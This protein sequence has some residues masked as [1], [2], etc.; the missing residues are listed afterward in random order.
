MGLVHCRWCGIH[1]GGRGLDVTSDPP[2]AAQHAAA[3][4]ADA[5]SALDWEG[6][7][8]DTR[9]LTHDIHRYSSKYIPQIARQAIN[10]ISDPGDL[11]LDPMVGSGTTLVEAWIGGRRALGIDLNPLAVLIARV[12]TRRIS[13][14]VLRNTVAELTLLMAALA[15]RHAG[16]LQLQATPLLDPT[17]VASENDPR[18]RD[19]WFTK[20]FQPRVLADLLFIDHAIR[21]VNDDR[22]RDLA[23]VALSDILRR[24]S[25]AHSGYPNVMFDRKAPPKPQPG[26]LFSA[27][28]KKYA[29]LVSTLERVPGPEPVV[30]LGDAR[31]SAIADNSIDAVVSH[32]PYIGSVPYAEYGLISLKW[33]GNDNRALDDQLLGG[34]RQSRDVVERFRAAY[35]D[36]L[37]DAYRVLRPGRRMFLMVGD[38]VVRGALVDLVEMT[39]EL[40]TSIGFAFVASTIRQGVNRRANKMAHE[41]L[42]FFEKPC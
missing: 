40:A 34:R 8:A 24:S 14:L 22:A 30:E 35:E 32:P 39:H 5:V 29:G 9:L 12:K 20:W 36:V 19:A 41:T 6:A 18:N 23:R 15:A 38:P 25:N 4:F 3:S 26:P 17:I 7:T 16:E 27:A 37:R 10:L 13:S 33:F 31:H 1:Q 11:I 28:L 2:L 42:L 21:R